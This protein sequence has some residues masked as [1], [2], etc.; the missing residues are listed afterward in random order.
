M[1]YQNNYDIFCKYCLSYDK[2]CNLINPCKCSGTN[3]YVHKVC[4]DEW[5][6]AINN[7]DSYYCELCKC[8]YEYSNN[9]KTSNIKN[10]II[11]MIITII[12][13]LFIQFITVYLLEIF[14]IN[15]FDRYLCF[16][17]IYSILEIIYAFLFYYALNY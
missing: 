11:H 14:I 5:R 8:K 9:E 2:Q 7:S 4:L 16:D 3:K 15:Q 1:I 12:I 6:L 10:K 17:N 13:I